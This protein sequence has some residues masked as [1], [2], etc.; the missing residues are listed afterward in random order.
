VV[1]ELRQLSESERT[2]TQSQ[3][4]RRDDKRGRILDASIVEIAR[5]GYH[6]TTVA[7][8]ARRAG[9]ADGTI[10]LYFEN[11]ESILAAVFDR[12][13]DHFIS[14]GI[15]EI[16]PGE[17]AAIRLEEIIRLHLEL[18]GQDHDLAVILQVELRHSLHFMGT[19]SRDRLRIYLGI[20]ASLIEHG[21]A[22]DVFQTTLAPMEAAKMVFGVLDQAV[23]DWILADSNSRLSARGDGVCEFI[24]T[25]LGKTTANGLAN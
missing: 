1:R 12:A 24:M 10:Y 2:F 15:L 6:S 13:M 5:S 22:R 14:E 3:Q 4:R 25:A 18:V 21:Q 20:M 8:I 7:R 23:T 11:K 17:N 9:V 16:S 19:F